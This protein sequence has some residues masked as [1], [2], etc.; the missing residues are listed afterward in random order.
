MKPE[1]ELAKKLP[2]ESQLERV[3]AARAMI[4]SSAGN[5]AMAFRGFMDIFHPEVPKEAVEDAAREIHERS[6]RVNR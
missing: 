6:Q 1:F 2:G 4:H 3:R 5:E